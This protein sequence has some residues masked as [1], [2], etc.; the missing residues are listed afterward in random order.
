MMEMLPAVTPVRMEGWPSGRPACPLAARPL[1]E[2]SVAIRSP[3]DGSHRTALIAERLS[4]Q[5]GS[6]RRMAKGE[7]PENQQRRDSAL[8]RPLTATYYSA[9][10]VETLLMLPARV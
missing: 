7:Q 5:R 8:P 2:P 1:R 9:P 10:T 3:G 6:Q 4:P